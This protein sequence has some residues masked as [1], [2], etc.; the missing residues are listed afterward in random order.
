MNE[1]SSPRM[2]RTE[3]HRWI[4]DPVVLSTIVG[5]AALAGI[6][7]FLAVGV[8]TGETSAGGNGIQL[9]TD[10]ILTGDSTND[11]LASMARSSL[12]M[13]LPIGGVVIGAHF[14]GG[15]L[16]SGAL[17]QMGVA[18]RRLRYLFMVRVITMAV[19]AGIAGAAAA[20]TTLAAADAAIANTP[21]MSHLGAWQA[22]W[23]T[24]GGASS[25]AVV[26]ALIAFGFSALTRRW[27]VVTMCMLVYLVGLEPIFVGLFSEWGTWM[28]RAATS[29]LMLAQPQI[30]HVL[31]TVLFA[32]LISIAAVMSLRRDRVAR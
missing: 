20:G 6:L 9:Q 31:P 32:L 3:I 17:I 12:T 8:A 23:P 4:R 7:T 19:F 13:L 21:E 28:P 30:I 27:V 5:L 29:E 18:A 1:L 24:I 10:T 14:A 16:A 11:E 22:G 26:I 2:A 25:Q 15:E